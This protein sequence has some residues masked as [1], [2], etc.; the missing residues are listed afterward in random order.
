MSSQNPFIGTTRNPF[1]G[2]LAET[3]AAADRVRSVKQFSLEQCQAAQ[4]VSDLQASV[5][6]AVERRIRKLR[7]ECKP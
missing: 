5:R 4:Q 2:E 3:V 6:Q 7:R 1:T